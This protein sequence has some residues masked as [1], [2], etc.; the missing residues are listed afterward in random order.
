MRSGT[1]GGKVFRTVLDRGL[2]MDFVLIAQMLSAVATVILAVL[3]AA[4][5]ALT[6]KTV[7]EMQQARISQDR[8]QVI[9]DADMSDQ[10]MLDVVVKNI[11][12]GAAR[13]IRFEFSHP[14]VTGGS[15]GEREPLSELAHF[16]DGIDYLAPGAELRTAW[17]TFAILTPILE[18]KGLENGIT[19]TSKY[20][21]LNPADKTDYETE[22]NMNLLRFAGSPRWVRRGEHD[23]A[24]TLDSIS[25]DIHRVVDFRGLKVI[26]R[27]E[28]REE[29]RRLDLEEAEFEALGD[30][31]SES[32]LQ[33]FVREFPLFRRR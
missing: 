7:I 11:G 10:W 17:S 21:A 5:V 13:N 19:I 3:T 25:K 32:R 12:S 22:W 2:L 18:A 27:S 20:S 9:V 23:I 16:K 1:I 4:N 29:N 26:T 8:P 33:R 24:K 28:Q 6:R 30:E 14:L 15:G 31:Q